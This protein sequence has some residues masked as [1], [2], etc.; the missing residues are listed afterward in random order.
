MNDILRMIRRI[1]LARTTPELDRRVLELVP[2]RRRIVLPA[3]A[4]M[5]F[6]SLLG[7]WA[8]SGGRVVGRVGSSPLLVPCVLETGRESRLVI[9]MHD[10]T[11]AKLNESSRLEIDATGWN[12]KLSGE[13]WARVNPKGQRPD[14]VI[15]T[16]TGSAR[17]TGTEFNLRAGPRRTH[18]AVAEGTVVLQNGRGEAKVSAGQQGQSTPDELPAVQRLINRDAAFRWA[19]LAQE[20]PRH[21]SEKTMFRRE[22]GEGSLGTL[23]AD[24]AA[25][26]LR[27]HAVDVKIED[28]IATT[29]VEE[30]FYNPTARRLEGTFLFPLPRDASISRFAMTI[31]GENWMEGVIVEKQQARAIY[32]EIVRR[33]TDPGLLEWQ[34]GGN[35]FSMRI[36]PIEPRQEKKIKIAYTQVLPVI[37][38]R[39]R[40]L[41]PLVSDA[42]DKTPPERFEMKIGRAHV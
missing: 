31:T 42:L 24:G 33:M 13:L 6:I 15:A 4:A 34:E 19:R 12:W 32:Q 20:R 40:Y 35:Q 23:Q 26:A 28:D 5:I 1:P 16:S 11:I 10:G 9:E 14:L 41:Y 39:A 27:R 7:V 30:V 17:I 38:G 36:F 18:L 25:L 21:E 29:T 8:L 22:S 2:R 3:A 37:D